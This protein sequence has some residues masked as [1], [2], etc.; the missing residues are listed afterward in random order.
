MEPKHKDELTI[1]PA[2][3]LPEGWEWRMYDDGSGGLYTPIGK[4]VITYDFSTSE[5]RD[6]RYSYDNWKSKWQFFS[7]YPYETQSQGEFMK[8]IEESMLA[9]IMHP[10]LTICNE[11]LSDARLE[12]LW[13][14]LGDIPFDEADVLGDM[15]LAEDWR[16]FLKGTDRH[17]IWR[18]FDANHSKGVA[19]LLYGVST[20]PVDIAGLICRRCKSSVFESDNQD[21]AYQ[22]K[23]C[24]EDLHSFETEVRTPPVV[25]GTKEDTGFMGV[26][27]VDE[28]CSHCMNE[29]FNIPTNR[30]S[31]CVHC[32]NELF[33]CAGC[34]DS[35]NGTCTWDSHILRCN[36]FAHSSK[37]SP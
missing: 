18:F 32:G 35:T 2:S 3:L 16:G 36:R 29:T 30:V 6:L 17:E 14:E 24:D 12:E 33:P 22:C 11:M 27:H 37:V 28:M 23:T 21:Y 1:V 31:L 15:V 8:S 4:Q 9:M 20:A 5:Y 34:D 26:G 19:F 10:D 13:A 25:E 7:G